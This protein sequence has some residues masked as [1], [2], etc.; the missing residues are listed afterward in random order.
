MSQ[1]GNLF[2]IRLGLPGS[3]KSLGLVEE[4]LLP[5]LLQG[6]EV[7]SNF[8]INWNGPN[9]HFFND[10]SEVLDLRNAV[11]AFDEIGQVLDPRSWEQESSDVRRFFQLHRHR[12]LTILGTTQDISLVAKSARILVSEWILCENND[13][14]PLVKWIFEKI[15]LG[16]VRVKYQEISFN[17]LQQLQKGIGAKPIL[18]EPDPSDSFS[19]NID[20]DDFE[21]EV[22]ARNVSFS[23]KKLLHKELNAFKT[24]MF[25]YYCPDC[26][27]RQLDPIPYDVDPNTLKVET[28]PKHKNTILK[29][30]PTGLFDTDY[31]I[32]VST[33][34]VE[35]RP[36]VPSPPG[37]VKIPYRGPL[38]KEMLAVKSKL[39]NDL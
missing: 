23:Y 33:H 11:I 1:Q 24:E 29:I 36:F 28:C 32:E 7:Y 34:D 6:E 20:F 4:D 5:H 8:W 22:K 16:R 10:I 21:F 31:D 39:P 26:C 27:S 18:D 13:D 2:L 12:H 19:E 30:K 25:H 9:L 3:G 38:S 35:W 15:G 17:E 37:H 14:S